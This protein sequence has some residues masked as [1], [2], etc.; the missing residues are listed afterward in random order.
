[1]KRAENL[2]VLQI[3]LERGGGQLYMQG[4]GWLAKQERPSR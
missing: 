2:L 3:G 4:L 1:M